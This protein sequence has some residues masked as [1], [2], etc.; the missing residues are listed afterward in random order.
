MAAN[1]AAPDDPGPQKQELAWELIR[2]AAIFE[3]AQ[4]FVIDEIRRRIRR[5]T[6]CSRSLARRWRAPEPALEPAGSKIGLL[7]D[8]RLGWLLEGAGG[9]GAAQKVHVNAS[10]PAVAELHIARASPHVSLNQL[11]TLA[12]WN[13]SRDPPVTSEAVH[14][15]GRYGIMMREDCSR[16][17]R[18]VHGHEGSR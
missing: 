9:F 6:E 14:A 2:A 13:Y 11:E 5:R 10:Y 3:M 15:L 7:C 4:P 16:T 12:E 8:E 1:N 17:D 18:A